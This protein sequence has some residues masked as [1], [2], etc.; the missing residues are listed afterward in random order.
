M[1]RVLYVDDEETLLELAKEFLES[2]NE[3]VLETATNARTGLGIIKEGQ[4][5]VV[6]SDYMMPE[7]DGLAFLRELRSSGN[8]IPFILF[9]GKGREEVVIQA[10]NEGADSYLQKGGLPRPQFAEL[11]HRINR[12]VERRRVVLALQQSETRLK[13]AEEIAGFGH[14]ELHLDSGTMHSSSGAKIIYGLND[15]TNPFED[16]RKIPLPKYRACLDIALRNLIEKGMAYDLEF[17]IT[18]V[19][20]GKIV[21]VH[22]RAEYDPVH[23]IVFGVLQDI[24]ERKR[25]EVDIQRKNDELRASW[26]QISAAEEE[27]RSAKHQLAVAMDLAKL[28]YWDMDLV[29]GIFIFNDSFYS[30]YGTTAEREGGY[31][32]NIGAYTDTFVHPDDRARVGKIIDLNLSSP[33]GINLL[34][35]RIIRRDGQMRDIVVCVEVERDPSGHPFHIYGAN[36]DVTD[37]R[38]AEVALERANRKL[39]LL[40][41]ITRH[42][43]TNQISILRGNLELVRMSVTDPEALARLQKV[44]NAGRIILD[45]IRFTKEYQDMGISAPRWQMVADILLGNPQFRDLRISPEAARLSVYADPMLPK[46]FNNLIENTVRY[47]GKPVSIRI[48]CEPR[49]N[50]MV[51]VYED[52]GPGIPDDEKERIFEKG[53]GK[54][55]G[56]GLFLSRE[57]LAITG[58][59]IREAG[60]YGHGARFE[61]FVPAPL[62]R[63]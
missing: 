40:N 62:F 46:V 63:R 43:I 54:G 5:D 41:S 21:D 6:V 27:L 22:S 25:A 3:I 38:K 14:W 23:R 8:D 32:M 52:V 50:G 33:I 17:K 45:Q 26:S 9:T 49:D 16:V 47:A 12:A 58:I 37:R 56:I 24:T 61:I 55:T 13:R 53:F 59:T 42:D 57:I 51:L 10:L 28:V 48:G 34:E 2:P 18:R 1:I 7:M 35:H 44:D 19:S 29:K 30:L 39:G 11:T 15:V 31:I 36:Q 20:D 60:T 4:I